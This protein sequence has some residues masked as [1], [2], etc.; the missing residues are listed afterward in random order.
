M[1]EL[2]GPV[3]HASAQHLDGPAASLAA[4]RE[5]LDG[6]GDATLGEWIEEGQ[7]APIM[8]LKRRVSEAEADLVG[9][10]RDIRGTPELKRR[11]RELLRAAPHLHGYVRRGLADGDL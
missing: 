7:R 1:E 8:H 6:V 9:G 10:I 2:G 4:C 5:A 3:W 11:A